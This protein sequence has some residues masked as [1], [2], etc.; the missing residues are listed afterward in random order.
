MT[1]AAIIGTTT[2]TALFVHLIFMRIQSE[3]FDSIV[4]E[5]RD[6][7]FRV[8]VL[9]LLVGLFPLLGFLLLRQEPWSDSVLAGFC[10]ILLF[11]RHR[12]QSNGL[13]TGLLVTILSSFIVHWV[14]ILQNDTNVAILLFRSGAFMLLGAAVITWSSFPQIG[15][16]FRYVGIYLTGIHVIIFT[17]VAGGLYS[18]MVCGPVWLILSLVALETA[19]RCA[20]IDRTRGM[21]GRFVLHLGYTLVGLFIV[22]FFVV[23][24]Q[25]EDYLAGLKVRWW[26][27]A[28]TIGVFSYWFIAKKNAQSPDYRSWS[29]LQPLFLELMIFMGVT[30]IALEVDNVFLPLSWI[31]IAIVLHVVAWNMTGPLARLRFYSLLFAWTSG[32]TLAA[33]SS[34]LEVPS[35][36]WYDQPWVIGT[37]T[38]LLQFI[39]LILT[40]RS[41]F[42]LSIEFPKVLTSCTGLVQRVSA[43]KNIWIFYPFF[44]TTAIFLYWRFDH[45]ILT[46]LLVLECF[47]I[48]ALSIT[49]RVGQFR[50]VALIALGFCI[51][52]LVFYDL[53]KTD[54]ITRG[55]VF[56]GVGMLMLGM[57]YI[58]RRFKPEIEK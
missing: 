26:I 3:R 7:G 13:A 37:T 54:T 5:G 19:D 53:A 58:Y 57:N 8:S 30:T 21:P 36:T 10:T 27:E 41:P 33:M 15:Q 14:W 31:V 39:Y 52:R 17:Y 55:I 18:P 56:V 6:D 34:T 45:A 49:L 1:V 38:I 35:L 47:I 2:L 32:V 44:A 11:I 24:I 12:V 29:Y 25:A 4:Q 43:R 40:Q 23:T 16:H 9:G 20:R 22:R 51:I 42:L 46:L 50:I 48:F 28:L